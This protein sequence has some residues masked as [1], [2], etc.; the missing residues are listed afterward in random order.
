MAWP[1]WA[2]CPKCTCLFIICT[3]C[4]YLSLTIS[5]TALKANKWPTRRPSHCRAHSK[6]TLVNYHS[7]RVQISTC[8]WKLLYSP[9]KCVR[10]RS[11]KSCVLL[12]NEWTEQTSFFISL[13][14][15]HTY[16]ITL[17]IKFIQNLNQK[18]QMIDKLGTRK[19]IIIIRLSLFSTHSTV[20]TI[21]RALYLFFPAHHRK[22]HVAVASSAL[23]RPVHTGTSRLGH[24]RL[25][26]AHL[27]LS[28]R[29]FNLLTCTDKSE[30]SQLHLQGVIHPAERLKSLFTAGNV[31]QNLSVNS[32]VCGKKERRSF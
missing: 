26:C 21:I 29:Q 14:C 17:C 18:E 5:R 28:K 1:Y 11:A 16:Q 13:A 23:S 24:A 7:Q 3:S 6:S 8:S 4:V 27:F 9:S 22:P 31:R 20:H 15:A 32:Y 19:C 2:L 25:K 10:S 30:T 12:R